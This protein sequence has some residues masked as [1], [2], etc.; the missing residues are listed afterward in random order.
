MD[1]AHTRPRTL[2]LPERVHLARTLK[3]H[4]LGHIRL[5]GL[6]AG[7]TCLGYAHCCQC[8][9]CTAD[10]QTAEAPAPQ[11]WEPRAKRAA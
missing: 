10:P 11:P 5:P 7:P 2:T 8:P 9:D 4:G 1:T 3:Q 6:T